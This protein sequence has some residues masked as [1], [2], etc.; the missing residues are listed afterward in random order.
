VIT[1]KR[2]AEAMML[3]KILYDLGAGVFFAVKHGAAGEQGT[4]ANG[5]CFS[6]KHG[7]N[8]DRSMHS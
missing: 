1:G 8:I 6:K 4:G 5:Q 3:E 7:D 2:F